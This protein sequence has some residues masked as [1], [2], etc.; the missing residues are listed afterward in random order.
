VSSVI[1]IC[2]TLP[3]EQLIYICRRWRPRTGSQSNTVDLTST[4]GESMQWASIPATL[5]TYL[6]PFHAPLAPA[7]GFWRS[8]LP[9]GPREI[10]TALGGR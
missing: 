3:W 8:P 4:S 9:Y 10:W 6:C 7:M 2:R 1:A 5:R